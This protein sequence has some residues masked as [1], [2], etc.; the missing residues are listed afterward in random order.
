ME[1]RSP[2]AVVAAEVDTIEVVTT[3]VATTTT[4]ADTIG[5]AVD[6]EAATTTKEAAVEEADQADQEEEVL[7]GITGGIATRTG[8]EEMHPSVGTVGMIIVGE[9]KEASRKA[10]Q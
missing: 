6:T 4:R 3:E 7:H 8:G 9:R 5:V 2:E 1:C 10:L